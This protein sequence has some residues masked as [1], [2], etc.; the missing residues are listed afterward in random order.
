MKKTLLLLL[1]CLATGLAAHADIAVTDGGKYRFV[2]VDYPQGHMVLGAYHNAVPYVYY[3]TPANGTSD[4]DCWW[5]VSRSGQGYTIRNAASGEYL[6]YSATREQNAS[7]E[8]L[9]KGLTLSSTATTTASQWTLQE[10]GSGSLIIENVGT[11]GQYFNLRKDGTYLVGTYDSSSD[12]NGYFIL[13]DENGN[14]VTGGGSSETETSDFTACVDSLRIGGKDVVRDTGDGTYYCPVPTSVRGGAD[15]TTT[16][17][18]AWA[19]SDT[20]YTLLIGDATPDSTGRITLEDL[21]CEYPYTMSI[22][23]GDSTV[24]TA[25]LQLTF[26][27]LVE[28]NVAS[29]NSSTYTTGTIRV[30]DANI[31]GYD[32]T[33]I[34]AYRW[35]GAS[36]LGYEKKSYAVKL[37]DAAGNSV[38]REYFGLRDDNN[39]ILDAMSVDEACMRN[40][41][42]TDLWNDFSTRPYHRR[43]GWE[44]KARTGTRG[45]FVEVFLNGEYH[46]IYCMTE[47]MDRKQLK[48]KKFVAATTTSA[49]T[50]HGSL[51]KS[52]Q[53]GYEVFMGHESDRNY[54]PKT[55][56]RSYDNNNGSESWANYEVKYPD[57]EDEK[58]D[59]GPL[60]NAVNFVATSTDAVFDDEV[61]DWFDYPVLTDYYLFIELMLATDNHGKNMFFFNYDQLGA[62]NAQMIGIAP[63][64]LDGTWGRRWDGSSNYTGAA[65]DFTTFITRY[66]HGTHTLFYRLQNSSKW[67]WETELKER[68]AELRAGEFSEESL[69][70]RFNDYAELFAESG[71]DTREESRWYSYHSDISA[72]V[73]Y[74]NEWI[75]DRL[76]YLDD[77]YSYV[78]VVDGISG[79]VTPSD[80]VSA[81]G[82]DGSITIHTTQAKSVNVYDVNGRLLRTVE[83]SQ[84]VTRLTGFDA[85]VY[86]VKD[87]KVIV[88]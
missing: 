16:V 49:D 10:N 70:A 77:Q 69:K 50:I 61:Q 1:A 28:V 21:T 35:R 67:D 76:A 81:T 32:S 83:L 62:E 54:Y 26:L 87:R 11:R 4:V 72:D 59:W 56:P 41:V 39:W 79:P 44:N 45:E 5:E 36:A 8:Y 57:Y 9:S 37:R 38:D 51:Y 80:Y 48:L 27:P 64:D 86:I 19:K 7:G 58:I 3:L 23:A 75:T 25:E 42:S 33:V 31:A 52:T 17:S 22:M 24:A 82:G 6:T 30:T 74:I 55:A 71:A 18:V 73:E 20:T 66:E 40:R 68:Y 34:A 46:G 13:Y 84:P 88:K 15:Y 65:Q 14:S 2:C 60:W 53:W 43:A 63:W 47:K 78:P 29:C 12:S 85:G